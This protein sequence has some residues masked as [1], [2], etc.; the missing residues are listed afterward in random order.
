MDRNRFNRDVRPALRE[1][2]IG[3]RGIAFDRLELDAWADEALL[4]RSQAA[5]SFMGIAGSASFP[6]LTRLRLPMSWRPIMNSGGALIA[7]TDCS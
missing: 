1:I 3:N 6:L 5:T 4:R 7:S 2:P